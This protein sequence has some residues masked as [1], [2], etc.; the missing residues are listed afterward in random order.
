MVGGITILGAFPSPMLLMRLLFAIPSGLVALT[1]PFAGSGLTGLT[2]PEMDVFGVGGRGD[3]AGG[4]GLCI[5]GFG[6]GDGLLPKSESNA[7]FCSEGTDSRRS[8]P[9]MGGGTGER[10]GKTAGRVGGGFGDE[11]LN[12]SSKPCACGVVFSPVPAGPGAFDC[13]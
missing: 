11:P 4:T 2:R 13:C 5:W 10:D 9:E 1:L 8:M 6:D 7:F 12:M 3:R